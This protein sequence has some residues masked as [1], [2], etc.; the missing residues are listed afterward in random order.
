VT[1]A[2]DC[3]REIHRAIR[4]DG[5]FQ[6][7]IGIHL[8]EVVQAEGD[9]FGDGVNLASRIHGEAAPGTIAVSDVVYDNVRNKEAIVAT[10]LGERD[11][12]HIDKL[13]RL[14]AIDV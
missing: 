6:V 11:L 8:G 13:I 12:K 14:Y 4:D 2:V 3:A 5:R 7:R 1:R 9:V 10:D